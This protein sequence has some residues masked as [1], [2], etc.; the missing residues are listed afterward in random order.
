MNHT[1]GLVRYE[2]KDEFTKDLTS[3]PDKIWKPE[4]LVSSIF[5]MKAPFETG[6]G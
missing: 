6:K 4:E 3:S 1:S 5:D 2:L